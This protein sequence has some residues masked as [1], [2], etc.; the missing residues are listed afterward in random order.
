MTCFGCKQNARWLVS[1]RSGSGE[2]LWKMWL[3]DRCKDRVM[4]MAH[5][6]FDDEGDDCLSRHVPR[7]TTVEVETSSGITLGGNDALFKV[8]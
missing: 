5:D 4:E 1:S 3:C 8:S 2:S 7:L 6:I